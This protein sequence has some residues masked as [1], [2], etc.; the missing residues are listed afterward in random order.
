MGKKINDDLLDE[1]LKGCERPEDLLGDG[2]LMKDLKKSLMQRMLGA[3]LAEH[4]GYEHGA[5]APPVQVNRRNGTTRKTVKSEDG[6]FEIEVPRDREGSF[7]PRLIAKGQTRID[8]LDDKIIAMYA[9]GM[10]VRDIRGHLEELYGLEV[11]PDLISRVTDA[12]LDEVKEWRSRAL[13]AVYPVVIFDALR[14]KIRDKDSRMVKN[15]A[16]YLALG[17]TGEGEREVLGLW[18]AEN[19]GA[20]FWLAVINELRNP[21]VGKTI[22]RIVL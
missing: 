15:K 5:E 8:G 3:E 13:D 11:S 22:P 18:I 1:L 17:I 4:L 14:V 20:K 7:E 10:S 16:V 6:S 2:G 21:I 12:V 9:R 19:E